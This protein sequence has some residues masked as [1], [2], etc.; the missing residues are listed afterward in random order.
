MGWV[1]I[2]NII[3]KYSLPP[4]NSTPRETRPLGHFQIAV[5]FR[6]TRPTRKPDPPRKLDPS[7]KLQ[8]RA[9]RT[10]KSPFRKYLARSARKKTKKRG[11]TY[12]FSLWRYILEIF[13]KIKC[14]KLDL[15]PIS[16]SVSFSGK[17][18]LPPGKLDR[19]RKFLC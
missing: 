1:N 13:R 9:F 18:D 7:R 2:L 3:L 16:E 4:G 19:F 11:K 15:S 12:F 6:E 14:Q 5:V 8:S 10:R 17:L